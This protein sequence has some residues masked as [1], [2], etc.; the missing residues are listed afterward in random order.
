MT[1]DTAPEPVSGKAPHPV[2]VRGAGAIVLDADGRLLVVLR[3]GAPAAGTWSLPGGKCE[4]GEDAAATAV[5]ECR[6]ETGLAVVAVAVVG[7]VSIPHPEAGVVYEVDDVACTPVGG[8][9]RAGDDAGDVRW[10][11]AAE[12]AALPTS[13]GLVDELRRWGRLPA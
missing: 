6:E 9:L 11:T 8:T 7:H 10:V 12:L 2:V 5:R 4:P 3:R 13:P 1:P